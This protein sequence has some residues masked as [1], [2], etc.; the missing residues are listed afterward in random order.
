MQKNEP[1]EPAVLAPTPP[2][3]NWAP[4]DYVF[5]PV[6]SSRDESKKETYYMKPDAQRPASNESMDRE[7]ITVDKTIQNSPEPL[8]FN[9]KTETKPAK[10]SQSTPSSVTGQV[11]GGLTGRTLILCPK[12]HGTAPEGDK[13]PFGFKRGEKYMIEGVHFDGDKLYV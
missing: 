12:G 1:K 7:Y 13:C 6:D 8:S 11:T 4:R 9:S 10:I 5:K 3:D 2:K